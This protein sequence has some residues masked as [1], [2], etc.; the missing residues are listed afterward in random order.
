MNRMKDLQKAFIEDGDFE[1]SEL[2]RINEYSS[3]F[4]AS[5]K[6]T[7]IDYIIKDRAGLGEPSNNIHI[8]VDISDSWTCMELDKSNL[9]EKARRIPNDE[10]RVSVMEIERVVRNAR[11]AINAERH[12]AYLVKK[13][14]AD[15]SGKRYIATKNFCS[16]QMF[17]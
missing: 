7:G 14:N 8:I 6:T 17:V 12:S 11:E 13:S 10:S 4:V 15:C 2:V 1:V 5:G 9:A 16:M 3:A